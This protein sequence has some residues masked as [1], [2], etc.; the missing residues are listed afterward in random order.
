MRICGFDKRTHNKLL[1]CSKPE[2]SST[3]CRHF[4]T[5]KTCSDS[6]LCLKRCL[7]E[8]NWQENWAKWNNARKKSLFNASRS[9]FRVR[10]FLSP[11]ESLIHRD[12]IFQDL[13][14]FNFSKWCTLSS[15]ITLFPPKKNQLW[16]PIAPSKKSWYLKWKG[17]FRWA[18]FIKSLYLAIAISCYSHKPHHWTQVFGYSRFGRWWRWW[19]WSLWIWV[20][21]G[22]TIIYLDVHGS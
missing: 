7:Y 1:T 3:D 21:F 19:R 20:N 9:N 22:I 13:G 16:H 11:Y 2:S 12:C 6:H 8:Q 10:W 5:S 14:W 18:R 17:V 15:P 4:A